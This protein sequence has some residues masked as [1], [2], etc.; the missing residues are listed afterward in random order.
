MFIITNAFTRC[1]CQSSLWK[2]ETAFF[3]RGFNAGD[4]GLSKPPTP[5]GGRG[6][7]GPLHSRSRDHAGGGAESRGAERLD[8]VSGSS[9][10]KWGVGSDGTAPT[11]LLARSEPGVH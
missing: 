8:L 3:G 9:W 7:T 10:G 11:A 1:V 6:Y 5:G 2:T 4:S